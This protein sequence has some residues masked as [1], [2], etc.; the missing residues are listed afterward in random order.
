MVVSSENKLSLAV[1]SFM[2]CAQTKMGPYLNHT[3]FSVQI[4]SG[5]SSGVGFM[6]FGASS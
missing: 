6:S 2:C 3:F 1:E 5:I 4:V